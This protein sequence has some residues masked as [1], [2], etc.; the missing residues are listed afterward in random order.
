VNLYGVTSSKPEMERNLEQRHAIKFCVKLK[1]TATQTY[2]MIK[3]AYGDAAASRSTVFE[4]HKLFRE[5]RDLVEDDHRV[6]RPSTSRTDD[7]VAKVKALLDSDR[8]LPVR[9]VSDIL[10]MSYGNVQRIITEDLGMRKIC[11]KLVPKVLTEDQ[12]ATRKQISEDVLEAIETDEDFLD[13]V[14]TGDESW[15]YEYDP[16]TK[17]QS[18]EWHT[19]QSPRQKK[20]RMSKSKIKSMLIVFFDRRGIIHKEF[21]PTGT[22]VTKEFY[23]GVLK[24]LKQ[25][26]NRVRPDIARGWKLHHD[27]APAHTA[28]VVGT[29]L[30]NYGV[31]TLPHPPYSPD[32]SPPDFFLFPRVKRVL[33]GH[34]YGT[35]QEVQ[36]A[37]TEVLNSIPEEDFAKAFDEWKSRYKRCSEAEGCYFEE[38]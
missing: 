18:S 7:S 10:G 35:I 9:L 1:K 12:K 17:Q 23:V 37:T 14:V 33:K 24:R 21:V 34:R 32:L 26:V 2:E 22:T 3:E 36:D 6:G 15:I 25:R 30:A 5:G 13:N 27:N 19:P 28:L 8:R 11:A 20:A 29:L 4:W 31:A 38:Y 16:E